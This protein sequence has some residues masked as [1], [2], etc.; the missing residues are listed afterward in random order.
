MPSKSVHASSVLPAGTS[1]EVRCHLNCPWSAG[2][3]VEEPVLAD[4]EVNYRIRRAQS[5]AQ[6]SRVLP[7][8][9]GADYVRRLGRRRPDL[10][11]SGRRELERSST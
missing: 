1:I 3:E 8:V 9:F 7:A 10:A 5:S 11:L 6:S 2:F 4:D